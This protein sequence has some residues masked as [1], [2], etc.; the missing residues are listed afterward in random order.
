MNNENERNDTIFFLQN[1]VYIVSVYVSPLFTKEKKT[2]IALSTHYYHQFFLCAL[3]RK[4]SP[5][6]SNFI[7]SEFIYTVKI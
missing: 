4:I 2:K 5:L 7:I 3:K 1:L 6:G